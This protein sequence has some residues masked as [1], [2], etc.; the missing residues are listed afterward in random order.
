VYKLSDFAKM[1]T[2]LEHLLKPGSVAPSHLDFAKSHN[3]D[4]AVL[5][6]SE[7]LSDS[8]S[9]L[10]LK[11]L[12]IYSTS[13]RDLSLL[14]PSKK[15][16]AFHLYNCS[17]T[18]HIIALRGL[19]MSLLFSISSIAVGVFIAI[20]KKHGFLKIIQHNATET[21]LLSLVLNLIVTAC[22]ESI[23]FVHAQSLQYALASESRLHFN[24]NLHL[25]TAVCRKRWISPNGILLNTIMVILLIMSYVSSSLVFV[26]VWGSTWILSPAAIM[27]GVVLW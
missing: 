6:A 24:T 25:V 20:S 16:D 2:D 17:G 19:I 21:E 13:Y 9:P 26:S 18:L 10:S 12:A 11:P 5:V 15:S 4:D 27:L 8:E 3:S 22:T 14:T 23:G 7:Y 1:S